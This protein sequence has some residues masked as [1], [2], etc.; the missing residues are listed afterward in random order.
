ML[1]LVCCLMLFGWVGLV[2]R[3]CWMVAVERIGLVGFVEMVS[4]VGIG[5]F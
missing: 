2:G 1:G 4:W 5:W 3:V